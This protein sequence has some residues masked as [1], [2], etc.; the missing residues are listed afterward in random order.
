MAAKQISAQY[1]YL[2]QTWS[3]QLPQSGIYE[4]VV[5]LDHPALSNR[6]TDEADTVKLKVLF[7]SVLSSNKGVNLPDTDISLP[8]I[9]PKDKAD[10]DFILTQPVNWIA[11]SFVR[12]AG[13]I[14]DLQTQILQKNHK[15]KIRHTWT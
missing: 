2:D 6:A 8:S 9:T 11:L 12:S 13:D 1:N 10:L 5:I 4:I 14:L 7:G 15:A 3:G